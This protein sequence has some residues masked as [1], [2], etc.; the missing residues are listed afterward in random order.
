MASLRRVHLVSPHGEFRSCSGV[1]DSHTQT[2]HIVGC[3]DV[4][5]AFLKTD[6]IYVWLYESQQSY[7]VEFWTTNKN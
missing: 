5:L 1:D 3:L 6:N 4:I 7:H 2:Y